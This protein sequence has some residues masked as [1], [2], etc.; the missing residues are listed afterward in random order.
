MGLDMYLKKQIYIGAQY[1][2]RKISGKIEI[3][4]DGQPI[5][6]NFKN[7]ST[8]TEDVGY[9]RKANQIHK[10]F[11]DNVQDG[12]DDCGE[13]YVSKEQLKELYDLCNKVIQTAKLEKGKVTNGYRYEN[14]KEI[15]NLENG[16]IITNPEEI[17]E[18]L[19]T[20]SGFFFGSTEYDQWYMQNIKDTIEILEPL[21]EQNGDFYYSSSW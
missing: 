7:V 5:Q 17:A 3:Y 4:K 11:V 9:W 12:E 21:L 8:I 6:I 10:W 2:R 13:Y 14:G 20:T 18:I 19:P 15:P 1:N 16:E